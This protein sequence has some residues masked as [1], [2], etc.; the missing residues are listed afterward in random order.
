[1]LNRYFSIYF[2]AQLIPAVIGFLSI[3]VFTRLLS[4]LE[5]GVYV[6]GMSIAGIAG[7]VF[8]AWI[9]LSVVRYQAISADI[10]FRGTALVAF[11]ATAVLVFCGVPAAVLLLGRDVDISVLCGSIFV[12]LGVGAF[13]ISQEFCRA[14]LKPV[15]YAVVGISRSVLGFAIGCLAIGIGWGGLGLL[16]AVGLSFLIGA[17][18][19]GL[20]GGTRL[21]TYRREHLIKFAR[22]GLPLSVGGLSFGLYSVSDRLVVAYLLGEDAAG[23]YGVATDLPRQFMVM[24]GSSVAAA[25]FPI[26]FRTFSEEGIAAT[27]ERL[28][29]NAELLLAVVVPVAVWL[30]FAASQV[31]GTLVG[32][33]FRASI[34]PLLPVLAVARMFG[35]INQFYVQISFQLS[36]RSALPIFQS[37][38][39]LALSIALMF[40]FVAKFGLMGAAYAA[41]MTEGTGLVLGI[42]LA[43]RAFRLPLE[44]RR[45]AGVLA[46]AVAMGTAIYAARIVVGGTGLPSLLI[47]TTAGGLAYAG[48][49]WLL[50]VVH[51]RTAMMSWLRLRTVS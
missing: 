42:W 22:Y 20:D 50:N 26:V 12:A 10:N 23:H 46:A 16:G 32:A 47:V 15:R 9:R 35:V 4:P 11:G 5:Y 34:L 33:D 31:V 27:R 7:S 25:T 28:N 36:E 24:L 17:L 13:D 8:F 21:N 37:V 14:S 45:L 2:G 38:A 18:A 3:T 29:E 49:A 51:V 48:A 40:P 44:P 43:R 41:L 1:M 19:S 6:V 30:S 39:T